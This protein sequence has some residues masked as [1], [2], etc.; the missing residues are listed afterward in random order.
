M[1]FGLQGRGTRLYHSFGEQNKGWYSKN[2]LYGT[3]FKD[4][5]EVLHIKGLVGDVFYMAKPEVSVK[6]F[7]TG[8]K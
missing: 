8:N 4:N 6:D 5:K 1:H 3:V 2:Y 7:S